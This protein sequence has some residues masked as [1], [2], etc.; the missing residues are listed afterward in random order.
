MATL[1]TGL[2]NLNTVVGGFSEFAKMPAPTFQPVSPNDVVERVVALFRAQL[3]A[4][5]RPPIALALDLDPSRDPIRAD[6]EQLGRVVQNLLLNAI[7]AM[8][9]GGQL[10][11]RTRRHDTS[12]ELQVADTG[13][14]LTEEERQAI[15]DAMTARFDFVLDIR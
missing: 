15:G 2:V 7:D 11:L 10:L 4:P 12:F 9:R 6:S 1:S 8:P 13:E 3:E 14:G 5:G